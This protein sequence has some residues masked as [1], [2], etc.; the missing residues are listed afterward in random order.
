MVTSSSRKLTGGTGEILLVIKTMS[1]RVCHSCGV[2]TVPR[3]T[4]IDGSRKTARKPR[5][6]LSVSVSDLQVCVVSL[7][8]RSEYHS[9]NAGPRACLGRALATYEGIAIACAT[10]QRFDIELQHPNKVYE[11]LPALNMVSRLECTGGH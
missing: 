7:T 11:P 9:W 6:V 4:P 3:S 2:R 5:I 8:C 1:S 10:L